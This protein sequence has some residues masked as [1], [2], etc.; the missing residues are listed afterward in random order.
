MHDYDRRKIT[1]KVITPKDGH[2]DMRLSP[3][4]SPIRISMN[5]WKLL[6]LI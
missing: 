6:D 4:R 3:S 2:F 5:D 1:T